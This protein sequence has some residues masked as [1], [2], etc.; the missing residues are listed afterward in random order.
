MPESSPSSVTVNSFKNLND[1]FQDRPQLKK[2]IE[3][4]IAHGELASVTVSNV[5]SS[6]LDVSSNSTELDVQ[7]NYRPTFI[8]AKR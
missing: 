1:L 6:S 7:N 3:D 5:S 2:Q 4:S 8:K